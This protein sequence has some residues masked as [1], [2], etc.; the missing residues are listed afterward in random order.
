MSVAIVAS[1]PKPYPVS[2]THLDVYKRQP[3]TCVSATITI[4]DAANNNI[5]A[6]LY[7][8]KEY[9]PFLSVAWNVTISQLTTDHTCCANAKP[10]ENIPASI[11]PKIRVTPNNNTRVEN[12]VAAPVSYTHL[13]VYKRQ[14]L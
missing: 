2:Y 3:L 12:D 10:I 5:L 14:A 1:G 8:A 13:D 6:P 7:W 4:I 9:L 11:A